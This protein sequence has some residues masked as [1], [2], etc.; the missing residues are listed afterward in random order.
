MADKTQPGAPLQPLPS[1]TSDLDPFAELAQI[2]GFD[3]REPVR[4]AESPF[5]SKAAPVAADDFAAQDDLSVD[6]ERELMGGM[7]EQVESVNEAAA[8]MDAIEAD[9]SQ[10]VD[11]F[12]FEGQADEASPAVEADDDGFDDGF[13]SAFAELD[14]IGAAPVAAAQAPGEADDAEFADIDMDFTAVLSHGEEFSAELPA[15]GE[16]ASPVAT[17]GE[18][19]Q[20]EAEYNA[21]L[22]NQGDRSAPSHA[23]SGAAAIVAGAWGRRETIAPEPLEAEASDDLDQAFAETAESQDDV[24]AS[25]DNELAAG[26]EEFVD[27]AS[28]AA[29]ETPAAMAEPAPSNRA[30]AVAA[31]DDPFAALV[32]MANR[33]QNPE[34]QFDWSARP[35]AA[36]PARPQT[37]A[38]HAEAYQPGRATRHPAAPEIETVELPDG[39][40]AIS[41]DLDLPDVGYEDPK[42]IGTIQDLDAEFESLLNSMNPT[43][44]ARSASAHMPQ[45]T[46]PDYLET[47]VYRA[48]PQ[49]APVRPAT[50]GG[51]D[52]GA[53]DDDLDAAFDGYQ[54]NDGAYA[55]EE[56]FAYADDDMVEP[57]D[58]GSRQEPRPRRGLFLAAVVGGLALIGGIGVVAMSYG[59][60]STGEPAL[61]KADASPVKIRPENPGGTTVPHQDN[62]VYNAVSRTAEAKPPRQVRLVSEVEEP[63]Q[64]PLPNDAEIVDEAM[65]KG[66]DRIK[67]TDVAAN[68]QPAEMI[69]V[70]PRKVRTMIVRP[71]GTLAP[72]E[73][74]VAAAPARLEEVAAVE[75][76]PEQ[77]TTGATTPV[78]AAPEKA[79][80]A[81][82]G[83]AVQVA[84]QP[85]EDSANKSLKNISRKYASVIGDRGAN[86]VKADVAGK[87]TYWR[88]RIA[89]SSRED[90]IGLCGKMKSAGGSCFVTK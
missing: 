38:Y 85:S 59:G 50:T 63:M 28:L 90:A 12:L 30:A 87:G 73:E 81:P 2:M 39:I 53:L 69:A 20:L 45:A 84:S 34:S 21:L 5:G 27:A 52:F 58:H 31:Q 42:S 41:D 18:A 71:D 9:I 47:P 67:P 32:A 72:R 22:G 25:L 7:D 75:Q 89:A 29:V 46:H 48:Q 10:S 77:I 40:H 80:A 62:S 36:E 49:Q 55:D 23:Q 68:D 88:V 4:A 56:E 76:E 64:I 6:L 57:V 43:E 51:N 16:I 86:I 70:S 17:S 11:T 66:E 19:D 26:T 35:V 54:A 1:V 74:P 15:A 13:D 61:I 3:P 8:E 79:V 37:Q 44:P 60:I 24:V 82:G 33:Y 78:A 83:W 14:E 65:A